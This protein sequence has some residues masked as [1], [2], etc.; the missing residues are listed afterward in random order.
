M[1]DQGGPSHASSAELRSRLGFHGTEFSDIEVLQGTFDTFER[2]SFNSMHRT[3]VILDT[4][5]AFY[6]ALE[7][8]GFVGKSDAIVASLKKTFEKIE[9]LRNSFDT[10]V[11]KL[12]DLSFLEKIPDEE[13][14]AVV[15]G[16]LATEQLDL[17]LVRSYFDRLESTNP[18][19]RYEASQQICFFLSRISDLREFGMEHIVEPGGILI[20]SGPG[21]TYTGYEQRDIDP[22]K[23]FSEQ[24]P[25]QELQLEIPPAS[26]RVV[27]EVPFTEQIGK[28]LHI[29]SA[30]EFV[31]L[32]YLPRPREGF[33]YVPFAMEA[34]Y[35][36]SAPYGQVFEER[37]ALLQYQEAISRG[38]I[39]GTVIEISGSI[40]ADFLSWV[41]GKGA[42]DF[43]PVPDVEITYVMQLPSGGTFH[44]PLKLP[45]KLDA[46]IRYPSLSLYK[47]SAKDMFVIQAVR[48]LLSV[49]DK[50][51]LQNL[52]TARI[53]D[54]SPITPET[55]R[56]IQAYEEAFQERIYKLL[57][58]SYESVGQ[59]Q[60]TEIHDEIIRTHGTLEQ[61]D[62]VVRSLVLDTNRGQRIHSEVSAQQWEE[63]IGA[64][65]RRI[66]DIRHREYDSVDLQQEEALSENRLRL[67]YDPSLPQEGFLL[68]LHYII[69]D[70]LLP[71]FERKKKSPV[72]FI[73]TYEDPLQRFED[74]SGTRSYFS[75]PH[76]DRFRQSITIYD[77]LRGEGKQFHT[78][79]EVSAAKAEKIY[80]GSL[81]DTLKRAEDHMA[82]IRREAATLD[83]IS[84]D[85]RTPDQEE[86]R[87]QLHSILDRYA[88][89]K[90]AIDALHQKIRAYNA[91]KDQVIKQIK[92][93]ELTGDAANVYR[94]AEEHIEKQTGMIAETHEIIKLYEQQATRYLDR[95]WHNI[96]V[97]Y[98]ETFQLAS[99]WNAFAVRITNDD[100]K[101]QITCTYAV[102]KDGAMLFNIEKGTKNIVSVNHSEL[103]GGRNVYGAGEIVFEK[104]APGQWRI[105]EVNNGSG[106]YRPDGR[107]LIYVTEILRAAGFDVSNTRRIDNILRIDV[108]TGYRFDDNQISPLNEPE[109]L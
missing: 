46:S 80:R 95:V 88:V 83:N 97:L 76:L 10:I 103:A 32:S 2:V 105:K 106:H 11:Q 73:P 15:V 79:H 12:H 1:S 48:S 96:A 55:V 85:S 68:P 50:S 29:S 6:Q 91:K 109:V 64:V 104:V 37:N 8:E 42:G 19:D 9:A 16:I 38:L 23:P 92:K 67:G 100:V 27:R 5:V 40:D 45:R 21:I 82:K 90:S 66:A 17:D 99:E 28:M 72:E 4:L 26:L 94:V 57:E 14:R 89:R 61:L 20:P 3:R 84:P 93:G 108:D 59:E 60:A 58:K 75:D 56:D 102:L 52:L 7:R 24:R 107:T 22:S 101:N 62:P 78:E 41:R 98:R 63:A 33:V 47:E 86:R 74:I 18:I 77:P 13:L 54:L 31:G 51:H 43:G 25:S 39:A 87:A 36:I 53:E 65:I 34:H 35:G 69:T 49:R 70:A 30:D 71:Y 81:I 44:F